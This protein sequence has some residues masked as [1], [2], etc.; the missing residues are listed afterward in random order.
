MK[1]YIR[2][3]PLLAEVLVCVLFLAICMS[4]CVGIFADAHE[5]DRLAAEQQGA[6]FTA[7]DLA[8][9]F[10]A[11]TDS[12]EDFLKKNG[13]PVTSGE[14]EI[15]FLQNHSFSFVIIREEGLDGFT[16]SGYDNGSELF[17]FPVVRYV[18]GKGAAA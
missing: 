9:R 16:I 6:L 12:A 3:T 7:Q 8:E 18:P 5:K 17:S 1:Q 11:G 4:V 10:L 14:A 15:T 13:I 2:S